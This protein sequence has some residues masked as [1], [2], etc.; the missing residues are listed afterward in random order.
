MGAEQASLPK[1]AVII[2]NFRRPKDTLE[3]LRTLLESDYPFFE[4]LVIDNHSGDGSARVIAGEFPGVTLMETGENLGYAEGNNVGIRRALENGA[5]YFF[6]LN[7]DTLVE[8][9]ALGHLAESARNHPSAGILAPK[10]CY[11]D[12][13]D[14]LNSCGT[15]VD[16]LRLR[17]KKSFCDQPDKGQCRGS[18]DRPVFPGCA[19]LLNGEFLKKEGLFDS[20]FFLLHEDADLCL[21][22]VRA[23][24]RNL[25]E[26]KAVIY[27]KVSRT[28]SGYPVMTAYFDIRNFLYLAERHASPVQKLLTVA[29]VVLFSLKHAWEWFCKASERP[30]AR[31]FFYGLSDYLRRRQGPFKGGLC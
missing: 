25:L 10:V 6:I 31:G 2:L 12:R 11:A 21:R 17:P 20:G 3:C 23:G 22:S 8:P 26:P 27:H 29:G 1:I 14:I 18:A 13:R 30:R 15:S 19:L 5:E 4:V 24:R 9:D 28:L 16:W 7:N